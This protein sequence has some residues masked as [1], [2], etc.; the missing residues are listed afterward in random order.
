MDGFMWFLKKHPNDKRVGATQP[1]R[2][3]KDRVY[4]QTGARIAP[5]FIYVYVTVYLFIYFSI[6]KAHQ[7]QYGIEAKRRNRLLCFRAN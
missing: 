7:I 1:D 3:E 2:L 5:F 6:S 4:Q